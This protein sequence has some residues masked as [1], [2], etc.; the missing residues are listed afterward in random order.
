MKSV[1]NR[2]HT[3]VVSTLYHHLRRWPNLKPTLGER[4]ENISVTFMQ[5]RPNV[6]DA[7]PTLYKRYTNVFCLLEGYRPSQVVFASVNF[8]AGQAWKPARLYFTLR[9]SNADPSHG[10]K[11]GTAL[12]WEAWT[13]VLTLRRTGL[14]DLGIT[15]EIGQSGT[16]HCRLDDGWCYLTGEPPRGQIKIG[17]SQTNASP[18]QPAI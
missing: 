7:G 14:G 6:F 2:E 3:L 4:L 8:I 9:R 16:L 5:R 17:N 12:G 13:R 1:T 11:V 18:I 15:S 10:V